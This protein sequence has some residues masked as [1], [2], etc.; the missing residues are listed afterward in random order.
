MI[1]KKMHSF[2][3]FKS[4]I[5]LNV[6]YVVLQHVELAR[7]SYSLSVC[8]KQWPCFTLSSWFWSKQVSQ[9][10]M[11]PK[12]QNIECIFNWYGHVPFGKEICV[13]LGHPFNITIALQFAHIFT[14]SL[15]RACVSMC[16]QR[17]IKLCF[18]LKYISREITFHISS[19]LLVTEVSLKCAIFF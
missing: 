10:H 5:L 2:P 11:L 13:I 1:R 16:N 9:S 17:F 18:L 7:I 3:L 6:L 8:W 15:Y 19:F 12:I 14:T 4:V